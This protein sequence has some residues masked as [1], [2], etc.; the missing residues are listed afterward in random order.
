[1]SDPYV[2]EIRMFAFTFAP[3]GWADCDGQILP[4]TQ[5]QTLFTLIGTTYGGDG[6]STF[7][8]PDLRSRVPVHVS[9]TDPL[10]PDLTRYAQGVALGAESIALSSDQMPAHQHVQPASSGIETTNRPANAI[11]AEGGVY[12]ASTT[13]DTNLAP[14]SSSG[15][16]QSHENRQPLLVVRFC[17]ALQGIFPSRS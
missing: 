10:G 1:V 12:R 17:I 16:S 4:T 7:A 14:T 2:G 9:G 8:L 5:N 11:P 6:V 15:G 3:T 13:G